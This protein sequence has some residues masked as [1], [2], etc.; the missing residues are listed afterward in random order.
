[1]TNFLMNQY[2]AL[3]FLFEFF[4]SEQLFLNNFAS[5][6]I[7]CVI[8]DDLVALCETSLRLINNTFPNTLPLM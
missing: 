6:S 7:F 5:I 2:L 4:M 3:Q 1:M 8:I